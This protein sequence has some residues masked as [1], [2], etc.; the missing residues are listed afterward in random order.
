MTYA[1]FNKLTVEKKN[2]IINAAI[3][4]FVRNGFG[5][6]STNE[7]VKAA[8]I[9]KGSLFNYFHRKKDLYIY[10][11]DYGT[12]VIEGL[13]KEIDLTETDLFKR[14]ENIGLQKLMIQKKYPLVFDFLASSFAEE[15]NE[16]KDEINSKV[17]SMYGRGT[18]LIYQNIDYSKFRDGIDIEK[19]IEIINWTMF[20]YGEKA[21]HQINSFKDMAEFGK[22]YLKEWQV[23]S[24]MLKNSFYK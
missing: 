20:G 19:A 1:N 8:K 18:E 24:D 17:D 14:I 15:A 7:I 22:E 10:L 11:V 9:S 16:V 2:Q 6:A 13:Y 3:Q 12:H 5:K 21:I 23:Y 4:E